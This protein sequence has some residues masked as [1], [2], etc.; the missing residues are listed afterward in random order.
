MLPE[1]NLD[2]APPE[3]CASDCLPGKCAGVR[4]WQCTKCVEGRRLL[5]MPNKSYGRCAACASSCKPGQ[6]VGE[7]GDQC[8]SCTSTKVLVKRSGVDY[9]TCIVCANTCREKQCV[10]ERADQCTSCD[11]PRV[12]VDFLGS[13]EALA[14][15]RTPK[16]VGT[17]T[18]CASSCA[19]AECVGPGSDQCKKCPP[20]R[21]FVKQGDATYGSCVSCASNCLQGHCAG[22]H[23]YQC[24][25]CDASKVLIEFKDGPNAGGGLGTCV[26]CSN[27]CKPM[28]C[29]GSE[30]TQCTECGPGRT[31]IPREGKTHGECPANSVLSSKILQS[32]LMQQQ[33]EL[34]A[35]RE[36][37]AATLKR[38]ISRRLRESRGTSSQNQVV[39]KDPHVREL[40][41]LVQNPLL[42]TPSF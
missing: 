12:L 35:L 24:T 20:E 21:A 17:C 5:L 27:T 23:S 1:V 42:P 25:K 38:R 8:T 29:V 6:C 32:R 33:T 3:V 37:R 4:S 18:T 9:G 22:P 19:I 15:N 40:G 11:H 36:E 2:A 7:R 28:M 13:P 14:A 16:E 31:L 34:A 10:G 41:G 30:T 39:S 26:A